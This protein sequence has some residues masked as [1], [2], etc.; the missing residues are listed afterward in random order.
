MRKKRILKTLSWRGIA[1]LTTIAIV[2][3]FTGQLKISL[4]AGL[5]EAFIK[6][7]LFY[8]HEKIWRD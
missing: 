5:F 6:I 1:T 7:G 3:A 8:L 2:Y 4:G